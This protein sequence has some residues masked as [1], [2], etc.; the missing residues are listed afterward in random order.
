M[1]FS[2]PLLTL[3]LFPAIGRSTNLIAPDS[4]I[5]I[6]RGG[7]DRGVPIP[8]QMMNAIEKFFPESLDDGA[9]IERPARFSVSSTE[10][11]NALRR[12]DTGI[13]SIVGSQNGDRPGGFVLVVDGTALLHVSVVW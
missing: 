3:T 11:P 5:I 12:V 13:S 1:H 4:N 6:V 10:R 2:Y 8:Q 7:N 9:V